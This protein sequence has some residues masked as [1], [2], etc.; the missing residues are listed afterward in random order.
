MQSSKIETD[1][2]K[3]TDPNFYNSKDEA[4]ERLERKIK[5]LSEAVHKKDERI[6][7]LERRIMHKSVLTPQQSN[8]TIFSPSKSDLLSCTEGKEDNKVESF[9]K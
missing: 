9:R 6:L 5:E 7:E 3:K 1:S 2:F 8:L 4:Y